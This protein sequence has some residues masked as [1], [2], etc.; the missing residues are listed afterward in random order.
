METYPFHANIILSACSL[1]VN[2]N[3]MMEK[4]VSLHVAI[5]KPVEVKLDTDIA[6][7]KIPPIQT[8]TVVGFSRHLP[9]KAKP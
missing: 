2:L 1:T 5:D 8:D 3:L 6:I 9:A 4:P 7:T